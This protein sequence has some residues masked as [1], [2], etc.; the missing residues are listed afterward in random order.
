MEAELH[1]IVGTVA[2]LLDVPPG[3]ERAIEAVLGERLQWVVVERFEH[4]RAAVGY[5][6]DHTLGAACA[7]CGDTARHTALSATSRR[8]IALP[9]TYSSR[10][11]DQRWS[12]KPTAPRR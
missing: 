7:S 3:M 1:G 2:D 11:G 9:V 12:T 8:R 10:Q 6:H 4:A 5:L